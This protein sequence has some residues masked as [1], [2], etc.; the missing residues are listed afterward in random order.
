MLCKPLNVNPVFQ[1]A[2]ES[3]LQLIVPVK[4]SSDRF[5]ND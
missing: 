3:V 1:M 4:I 5:G 2:L